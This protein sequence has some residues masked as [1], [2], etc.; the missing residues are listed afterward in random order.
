VTTETACEAAS[1]RL[2]Q[3]RHR[4]RALAVQ[5]LYQGE[6]G[7]LT[8]AVLGETFWTQLPEEAEGLSPEARAFA[9]ELARGTAAHI[10][11]LDPLISKAAANWRLERFQVLDRIVLRLA[12][13]EL[14]H[15]P[16]TPP[17]VVINEALELART[18][19]TEE[20]V[21]FVNGVLDA[22]HLRLQS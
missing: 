20:S 5:M 4:A 14:R 1:G 12:V 6:V 7:G 21:R 13:Y 11:E 10:A 8:V 17:R 19:G 3:P 15:Q 18:F 16:D 2:G 9:T 22:I